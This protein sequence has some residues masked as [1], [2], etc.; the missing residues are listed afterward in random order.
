MYDP[1]PCQGF[2]EF[3]EIS[4]KVETLP[5]DLILHMLLVDQWCGQR[6][7]VVGGILAV[8]FLYYGKLYMFVAVVR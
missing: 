3:R 4:F 1:Q 7:S 6:A 8:G 5:K 2:P